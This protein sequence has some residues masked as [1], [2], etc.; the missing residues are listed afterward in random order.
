MITQLRHQLLIL[1]T[2]VADGLE[3]V[4]VLVLLDGKLAKATA[5]IVVFLRQHFDLLLDL[6]NRNRKPHMCEKKKRELL[7]R[8]LLTNFRM[9]SQTLFLFCL[10]AVTIFSICWRNS[11]LPAELVID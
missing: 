10:T 11:P 9:K 4:S 5:Q 8:K 6:M 2:L 1:V 3:R 7:K